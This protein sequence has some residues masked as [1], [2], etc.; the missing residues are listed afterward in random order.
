MVS[1]SPTADTG[2]AEKKVVRRA[3]RKGKS[4][5]IVYL[6]IVLLVL[7]VIPPI[8]NLVETSLY[9]TNLDGSFGEFTF[10]YFVQLFASPRFFGVTMNTAI[11]A[12]GTAVVAIAIGVAQAWI[13]ERTDTPLRQ[14][15]FLFS[16]I[17]L[18][19]PHVLFTVAWVLIL[20]KAGPV[21]AILMY[22]M[23]VDQPPFDVYTLGGMIFI[24]AVG[25]VPL[26]FLLVSSVF[27]SA[28]ASF[29]EASLMSSA[30]IGKTFWRITFRL[31]LPAVMAVAM[32][33][34]IRSFESF[35]VPA[36]IGVPGRVFVLSTDIYEVTTRAMPPNYGLAGA[37]SMGLFVMVAVMLYFY[38]RL[39]RHASR[40]QTI[41]G[42]G[43][44][45]RPLR[46]GKLRWLTGGTLVVFFFVIILLPV[47][48][49]VWT[50][51]LPFYER[52]SFAGFAKFT[53]KNYI[54]IYNS[55]S[56]RDAIGNTLLLG[57]GAALCTVVITVFCAW[58]SARRYR[59]GW[60]LDQLATL[61]L[62]FPSIVLGLSM[63]E[64][65]LRLPFPLYGTVWSIIFACTINYLPYGMRYSYAGIIQVHTELEEASAMS[66]ATQFNTFRRVVAPLISPA[67]VTCS[68][69]IF[70][71]VVRGVSL[72]IMLSGPDNH[73]VAVTLFERWRE[74]L[75]SETAALGLAW[76]TFMTLVSSA[77]YI[78]GKRTGMSVR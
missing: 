25:W 51:F 48:V 60:V 5:P 44:R 65:F 75:L 77:F 46:L 3:A 67:L 62:V 19:V 63:L 56:V 37:F 1:I 23:G 14:Y 45:P 13:V 70:L 52:F 38:G 55:P 30:T 36:L 11:Y 40:Y 49:L 12:F 43:Y 57:V 61:P 54:T 76:G 9:T 64:L 8:I 53:L 24:E 32:L 71:L 16:I 50:S 39:S 20:G 26:S 47:A 4:S 6:L 10:R 66:G 41:T 73:I 59:F 7:M 28:D 74:G 78:L 22:F 33:V 42:K 35:E 69:F 34:L 31:A 27:R 68:L 17:S 2:G 29:E 18:G 58:F 15:V 21:N 72:P